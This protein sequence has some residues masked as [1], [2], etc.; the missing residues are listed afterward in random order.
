MDQAETLVRSVARAFLETRHVLI[1][2]AIIIHSASV[3]RTPC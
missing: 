2:D 3:S 1:I